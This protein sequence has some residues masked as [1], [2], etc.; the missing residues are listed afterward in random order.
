M[1]EWMIARSY[2]QGFFAYTCVHGVQEKWNRMLQ[3]M[4]SWMTCTEFQ[5]TMKNPVIS[6][7][8]KM[9]IIEPCAE[10]CGWELTQSMQQALWMLVQQKRL[11]VLMQISQIFQ[12]CMSAQDKKVDAVLYCAHKLD[13][14][15]LG[16]I[17]KWLAKHQEGR[18]SITTVQDRSLIGGFKLCFNGCVWDTSIRSGLKRL[19]VD[20]QA[21]TT[22]F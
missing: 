16:H 3:D 15:A 20:L 22:M 6:M 14:G 12:Q 11:D 4:V 1:S 17:E 19:A 21:T 9:S 2:A 5:K 10:K 13:K 18:I 7:A 8:D